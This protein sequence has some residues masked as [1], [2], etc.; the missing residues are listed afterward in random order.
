LSCS[1]SNT[2]TV[3]VVNPTINAIGA[4]GCGAPANGTLT[5]NAF[6]TSTVNWYATSTPTG[7]VLA[8]GN[9]YTLSSPSTTTVYAQATS[10]SIGFVGLTNTTVV[11]GGGQQNSTNYNIFDVL[12][13][14]VIQNVVVYPG[15]AGNVVIDLRD[16]LGALI[17]SATFSV[18]AVSSTVLPINFS[19]PVG[20][21]YR[22]G[23]GAGSVSMYRTS[24]ASN[25]Y[26]LTLPGVITITNSAA[27]NT[28]YYFCYN[29]QVMTQGC[30]SPVTP[31]VFTVTPSASV[32]AVASNTAV[33]AGSSSTLTANGATS[34]T[35]NPG[36]LTGS[37][38]VVSP[39]VATTYTVLGGSGTCTGT[40]VQALTVNPSPSV[41]V[42][43]SQTIC[44]GTLGVVT[45][46]TAS[47]GN[48]FTWSPGNSNNATIVVPTPTTTA[49]YSVTAT[50]PQ[51]CR[52]TVTSTITIQNCAGTIENSLSENTFIFPNP[53][54]GIVNVTL[55]PGLNNCTIEIYEVT[56]RLVKSTLINQS[57]SNI[58]LKD[59]ANGLY[60]YKVKS[61]AKTVIKEGKIVKE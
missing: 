57:Q 35:W 19:V 42:S 36:N 4:T 48:T 12:T 51:G 33:C 8:T 50:N 15:A 56:G 30:T 55:A 46:T 38:V 23:Q 40:A 1:A 31:V 18:G 5:A 34:Y 25:I 26:P 53:T 47:T 54:N 41:A 60:T 9:T 61:A 17:S 58:D 11:S 14:C 10:Q 24:A 29:W 6:A 21:G 44:A 39:T 2:F 49:V 43:P 52:T 16:N 7:A 32:S 20:N 59:F 45:L 3:A 22:L 27:G 28:F 37:V 13:P